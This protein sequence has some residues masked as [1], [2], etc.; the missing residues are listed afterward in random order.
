VDALSLECMK[1]ILKRNVEDEI[2]SNRLM[3]LERLEH[4]NASSALLLCE[5]I[6][7]T[8]LHTL[9]ILRNFQTISPFL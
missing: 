2:L 6:Q 5:I 4:T 8:T 3:P 1:F 7:I 9:Y